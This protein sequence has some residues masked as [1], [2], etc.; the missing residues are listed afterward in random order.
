M[1]VGCVMSFVRLNSG[2]VE[3]GLPLYDDRKQLLFAR[4]IVVETEP[5]KKAL[6]ERGLFRKLAISDTSS[7]S[8]SGDKPADNLCA[9][10]DIKLDIGDTL[11]LQS[12]GDG[13]QSRFYVRHH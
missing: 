4:G 3:V 8:E 12:Q 13:P 7:N 2:E 11:P 6:I 5:W 1:Q 10:D 9:V